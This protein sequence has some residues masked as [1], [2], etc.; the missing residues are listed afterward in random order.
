MA[1]IKDISRE[2]NLGVSTVSMALNNNPRISKAT[3]ELVLEKAKELKYVKN[4]AAVDLQKRKT[5]LILMVVNDPA[6]S[7]FAETINRIQREV[8]RHGY[9]FL[10]ATTFEGH[11]E[12]AKRYISERRADAVIVYTST[13]DE[14]FIIE[15][16]AESFPIFVL[17]REIQGDNVYSFQKPIEIQSQGVNY[18]IEKGHR[19]IAFVKGSPYSLGTLRKFR[20]YMY[21]LCENGIHADQRLIFDAGGSERMDGYRITEEIIPHIKDIDAIIYSNDE[22][23]IGGME[24]LKKYKIRIPEDVSILGG[25]NSPM[26]E[27]VTPR[28]TS[29]GTKYESSEHYAEIIDVMIDLIEGKDVSERIKVIDNQPIEMRIIE[30][31]TVKDRTSNKAE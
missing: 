19:H 1:T 20:G 28:L 13:I 11:D 21:G 4:T 27:Y 2:L 26:A 7:F 9:D 29:V 30:R 24:C 23:A 3:R 8:A 14:E 18:L 15:N 31:E 12:T 17:G 25:N 22:I 10:I 5:N 16:A 6:R